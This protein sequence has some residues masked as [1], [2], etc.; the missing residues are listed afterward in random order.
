MTNNSTAVSNVI[1]FDFRGHSVTADDDNGPLIALMFGEEP[2]TVQQVIDTR[3]ALWRSGRDPSLQLFMNV[4]MYASL[5]LEKLRSEHA[6]YAEVAEYFQ[7]AVL[8]GPSQPDLLIDGKIPVEVK[9]GDFN[10]SALRQLQRYMSK[11]KSERGVAVGKRLLVE[12][13]DGITFTE[14]RFDLRLGKYIAGSACGSEVR[15]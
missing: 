9:I 6:A 14:I 7:G 2:P 12:L 1:P 10:A 11:Y 4:V 8:A 13:P 15:P 3:N 5:H